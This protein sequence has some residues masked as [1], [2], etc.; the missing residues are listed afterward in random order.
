MCLPYKETASLFS[1]VDEPFYIHTWNV[2]KIHILSTLG[3][4]SIF[5]FSHL[6]GILLYF[7]V[8]LMSVSLMAKDVDFMCLFDIYKSFL[9]KS[10]QV[11]PMFLV[12][13]FLFIRYVIWKYLLLVY[14]WSVHFINR[15]L[16]G[17]PWE[18]S[19]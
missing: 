2:W 17:L 6:I 12:G 18:L 4:V 16:S 1:K 19:W 15:I 13:L 8:V 5:Y 7:I 3:V 11:L 14:H 10:F 9:V